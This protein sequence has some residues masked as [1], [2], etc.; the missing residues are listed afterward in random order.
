[1]MVDVHLARLAML[2][3]LINCVSFRINTVLSTIQPDQLASNAPKDTMWTVRVDANMLMLI[4][5]CSTTQESASTVIGCT[6]S[7][8]MENVN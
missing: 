2:S 7:T 5:T 3:Q 6:S 8:T 1:M 4:A